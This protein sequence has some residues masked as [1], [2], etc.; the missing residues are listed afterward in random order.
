[1]TLRWPWVRRRQ[2]R[3][4]AER[5]HREIQQAQ[6]KADELTKRTQRVLRENRFVGDIRKALGAR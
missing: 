2:L 4:D 6:A 5:R 1:M 3:V